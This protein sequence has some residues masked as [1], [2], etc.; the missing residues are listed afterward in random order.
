MDRD[1]TLSRRTTTSA[2]G[3]EQDLP[4]DDLTADTS[5]LLNKNKNTSEV[6]SG[7][8]QNMHYI[9]SPSMLETH[10]EL[11]ERIKLLDQLSEKQ[12]QIEGR[13][14]LNEAQIAKL[15]RKANR[16]EKEERIKMEARAAKKKK[17]GPRKKQVSRKD[18]EED[19]DED[20]DEEKGFDEKDVEGQGEGNSGDNAFVPFAYSEEQ[21][22]EWER[23]REELRLRA[24][25]GFGAFCKRF[26]DAITHNTA[27]VNAWDRRIAR[28][29]LRIK[30]LEEELR[31]EEEERKREEEAGREKE[32]K[33]AQEVRFVV[34]EDVRVVG[35]LADGDCFRLQR[36]YSNGRREND[37]RLRRLRRRLMSKW[38]RIWSSTH[39]RSD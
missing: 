29:E 32:R 1:S 2:M 24:G 11:G 38:I 15:G 25:H 34:F 19:H 30:W 33:E 22:Q 6:L 9:V 7:S 12:A 20:Y 4:F 21:I 37:V 36:S 26:E 39:R 8:S 5:S 3:N 13:M 14:M 28:N 35:M 23:E 16:M 17:G 31:R 27:L 18:N 10:E